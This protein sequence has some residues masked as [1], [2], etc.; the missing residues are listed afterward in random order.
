[1]ES[2]TD[3]ADTRRFATF[4]DKFK[5]QYDYYMG[6]G[7]DY[8][9]HDYKLNET[10]FCKVVLDGNITAAVLIILR[11]NKSPCDIGI[12]PIIVNP[13]Y[14]NKGYCTKIMAE[15][16]NNTRE[17][18]GYDGNFFTAGI[19][20]DNKG[21]I[22]AFE[23]VGFVLAGTHKDGSFTYWVYPASELKDYQKFCADDFDKAGM[24][25]I[26]IPS[27]TA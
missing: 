17:I 2:W 22:K 10:F 5:D 16:I 14:R 13:K 11:S 12:N 4:D 15:L 25:D 7:D 9:G 19:D 18:I 23:K 26:F 20:T 27:S 24:G 8:D 1:M 21:S 6:T 3:D